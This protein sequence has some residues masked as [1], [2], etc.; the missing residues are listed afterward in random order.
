MML[1]LQLLSIVLGIVS[2]VCFILIIV[3]M[4]Q[5]DDVILGVVGLVGLLACGL[6]ALITFVMGWVNSEKY[7]AQQIMLVWTAAIVINLL[8]SGITV[9]LAPPEV[10]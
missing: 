8:I 9:A 10:L 4:F 3:K 6:G 1:L 7:G 2:L 5:S